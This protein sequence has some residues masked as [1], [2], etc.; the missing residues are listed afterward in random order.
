MRHRDE[1]FA[2]HA[3]D[4]P[5]GATWLIVTITVAMLLSAA[6]TTVYVRRHPEQ[7]TAKPAPAKAMTRR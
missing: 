6:I 2:E 7:F 4:N 3:A 1:H 5:W